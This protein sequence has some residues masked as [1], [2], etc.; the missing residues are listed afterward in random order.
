MH[1]PFAL[2]AHDTVNLGTEEL[3]SR[4]K[5]IFVPNP[6]A[7]A[8]C[9]QHFEAFKYHGLVAVQKAASFL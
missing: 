9:Y 7:A 3:H 4:S 5:N 1:L 2:V 6:W 8:L